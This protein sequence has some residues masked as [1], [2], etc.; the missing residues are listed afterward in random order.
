MNL[1][2]PTLSPTPAPR[3]PILT[4]LHPR[5]HTWLLILMLALGLLSWGVTV[6]YAGMPIWGAVTIVLAL[7]LIP[8]VQKWRED[9]RRYGRPVMV[10]SILLVM[11]GF[12]MIEHTAQV[13]Q[14]HVWDWFPYQSQGLISAINVELVHFVWNW[15]IV[16]VVVY[17][18]RQGMRNIWVWL[19]LAWSLAHSLEHTY[20]IVR[21]VM[22]LQE[23][24]R[25]GLPFFPVAQTLPGILGRNGWLALS[26]ICGRIPG[27][28]TAPRLDIHFWWNAGELSLLLL[29]AHPFLCTHLRRT[30]FEPITLAPH[31]AE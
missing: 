15:I 24:A 17:L 13:I 22:V 9:L 16:V 29:A 7:L 12:H 5:Q 1:T 30:P 31:R 25:L 4:L 23:A 26:D 11:Q 14:Y 6:W 3:F 21:Y 28:T 20:L 27:L 8:G 2:K 10:L 19:L 18:V